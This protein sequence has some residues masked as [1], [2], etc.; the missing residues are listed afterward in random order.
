MRIIYTVKEAEAMLQEQ[1]KDKASITIEQPINPKPGLDIHY[2]LNE[3]LDTLRR[4]YEPGQLSNKI[5]AVKKL[6]ENADIQGVHIPLQ[7]AVRFVEVLQKLVI[8]P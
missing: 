4:Q 7:S 2:V 3:V 1:H 5:A 6:K 8:Y